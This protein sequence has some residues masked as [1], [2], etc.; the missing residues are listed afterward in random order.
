M[1]ELITKALGSGK[2]RVD[3]HGAIWSHHRKTLKKLRPA[4]LKTG[5][6]IV[7]LV[8]GEEKTTA[9]V[10]RVVALALIP[11]PEGKDEVNHRD[12]DKTNN[13]PSNLEWTTP[14]EN[15]QHAHEAGQVPYRRIEIE[16]ARQILDLRK[17]G[18]S[19]RV[20][21]KKTGV[22]FNTVMSVVRAGDALICVAG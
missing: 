15:S 10:H 16:K 4:T 13:H 8:V 14:K 18:D 12:F 7:S 11:N 2:Y 9:Y 19:Y 20:I 22:A 5:Y 3:E 17:A 1:D 21:S 6:Q